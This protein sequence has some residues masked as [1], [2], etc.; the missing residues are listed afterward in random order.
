[1]KDECRGMKGPA[2]LQ[3]RPVGFRGNNSGDCRKWQRCLVSL[4]LSVD[5]SARSG[6]RRTTM[7]AGK[8]ALT[9]RGYSLEGSARYSG[10]K[11][12]KKCAILRN[13]PE[14]YDISNR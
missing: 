9:E 2:T 1:M 10:V 3:F 12:R 11:T 13:E 4:G 14:L 6:Y 8:T 7:V 5:S